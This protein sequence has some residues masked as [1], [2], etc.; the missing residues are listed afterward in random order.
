MSLRERLRGTMWFLHWLGFI[1]GVWTFFLST[2]FPIYLLVF[3]STWDAGFS[4][5]LFFVGFFGFFFYTG[6]AWI[7]R[8]LIWGECHFLPF[9]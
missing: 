4:L 7:L 2:V 8:I 5:E 9:K 1:A 3:D 6:I